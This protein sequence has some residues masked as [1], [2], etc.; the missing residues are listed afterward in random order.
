MNQHKGKLVRENKTWP[1]RQ[2][3]DPSHGTLRMSMRYLFPSP[4]EHLPFL[5]MTISTTQKWQIQKTL[6]IYKH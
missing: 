6:F 5:D 1:I 4:S 3:R 2:P